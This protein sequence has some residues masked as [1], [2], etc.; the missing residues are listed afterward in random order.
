MFQQRAGAVA[1]VVEALGEHIHDEHAGV[2][3]DEVGQSEGSHRVGHA[4]AHDRV[5]ILRLGDA[6]HPRVE[7]FIDHRHQHAVGDEAGPVVG[8]VGLLAHLLRQVDG[9][10]CD[11]GAGREAVDDL[12]ELHDRDGVEEVHADDALS[13]AGSGDL[14]RRRDLR[15]RDGRGVRRE[16]DVVAI[17]CLGEL[18][19]ELCLDLRVLDGR[20]DDPVGPGHVVPFGR[21]GDAPERGVSIRLL[22]ATLL[23][24]SGH[25]LGVELLRLV[26]RGLVGV[27][28]DRADAGGGGDL[29]DATTHLAG[30]D[31]GEGLAVGHE[32]SS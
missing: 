31:D 28:G 20:L 15:N 10:L 29:C 22:H 30:T 17:E 23:D 25:E 12:D 7:R 27:V 16:D 8:G 11:L 5:D 14:G 19:K 13:R 6:L 18:G 24:G 1:V 26:Q 21:V 2:Q 9:P 3:P 4:E 32:S